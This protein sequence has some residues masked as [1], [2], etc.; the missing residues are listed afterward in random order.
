MELV[1]P[2]GACQTTIPD[3]HVFWHHVRHVNLER[4]SVVVQLQIVLWVVP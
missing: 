2:V 3:G 4:M 1:Q